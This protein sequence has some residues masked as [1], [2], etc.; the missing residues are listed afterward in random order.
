MTYSHS[1]VSQRPSNTKNTKGITSLNIV[2]ILGF[3]V[4]LAI[5]LI[6]NEN[7]IA[8]NYQLRDFEKQLEDHQEL[9]GKLEIKQTEQGSLPVLEG[10]AKDLQLIVIDKIK[11]LQEIESSV[12]LSGR[13]MP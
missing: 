5:F 1:S 4:L 6:E 9:I 12:A 10:A 13:L 7:L 2:V 11:Y 8:K 3:V